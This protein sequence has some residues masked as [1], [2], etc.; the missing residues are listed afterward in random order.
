MSALLA[1]ALVA[2]RQKS[3]LRRPEDVLQVRGFGPGWLD[4][5]KKNVTVGGAPAPAPR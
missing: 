5:V 3:P 2:H 1:R 4:K